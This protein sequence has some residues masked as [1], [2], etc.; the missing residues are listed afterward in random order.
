MVKNC[1]DEY[2]E[3]DHE[4]RD[5]VNINVYKGI[6]SQGKEMLRYPDEILVS[7]LFNTLKPDQAVKKV[8]I[9]GFGA[10]RHVS[11]FAECGYFVGGVEPSEQAVD[12]AKRRAIT[13]GHEVDLQVG[14]CSKIPF[15]DE[16]FDV[17]LC[18]G[19]INN[20]IEDSEMERSM[21]EMRRVL[22]KNG[23]LLI[24]FMAP[25]DVKF[26]SAERVN[27]NVYRV[28]YRSQE[29]YTRFWNR[30]A[31]VSFVNGWGY[32]IERIGYVLRNVDFDENLPIAYYVVSGIKQ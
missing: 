20:V 28:S 16:A 31:S 22:R 24:S 11:L 15:D 10:G 7:F 5:D 8:M 2:M 32:S 30:D 12:E 25:E 29:Y 3:D 9:A 17:V 13:F 1:K 21:D 6:Y 23:R 4:T 27:D 14:T 26:K 18:W 19:V